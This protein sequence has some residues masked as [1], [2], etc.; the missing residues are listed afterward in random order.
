MLR[1]LFAKTTT[2]QNLKIIIPLETCQQKL[3]GDSDFFG[4]TFPQ[5]AAIYALLVVPSLF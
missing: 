4:A 5:L 1:A 2:F 3:L